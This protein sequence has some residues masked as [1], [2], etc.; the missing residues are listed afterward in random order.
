MALAT[1]LLLLVALATRI[2][3]ERVSLEPGM[4]AEDLIKAPRSISYIDTEATEERRQM[5]R[6][7][8][9]DQYEGVP[10]ANA[11]VEQTI[12]D[13]FRAFEDVR[14]NETFGEDDGARAKAVGEML[15]VALTEET[16][17]LGVTAAQGALDR[18]RD[19]ALRLADEE[20]QDTVRSNTTD[21]EDARTSVQQA[22]ADLSLTPKFQAMVAEIA[23]KSLRPNLRYDEQATVAQRKMAA[24][25]VEEVRRQIQADDAIVAPGQIV[26]QRHI[27]I[28]GA[29]GLM[30]PRAD[31]SQGA[32]LFVLLLA[33]VLLL[34][35]YVARYCPEIYVNDRQ[36]LLICTV[37]VLAAAGFRFTQGWSVYAAFVL[38]ISTALAMTIAMLLGTRLAI[39][40]SGHF[41]LLAGMVATGS[42][43][44]VVV[45]T[46]LC[47]SFA[48][49]ALSSAANKSL[50]IARAA[51]LVGLINAVLF[52]V[53]GEVFG[54]ALALHQVAATAVAG[55]LSA[56][57]AVVA[58]MAIERAVGVVTDLSLLELTNPN[59]PILS[60]LLT[61]APGTYQS[62]VMVANLAVPAAERIGA[63][64]L[65]ARAGALYH[66]IGKLKRPYFFIENQFGGDN[67]HEK[68]RPHLSALTLIAHAKDGYDLAREI[69]LPPQI[70]DII[71]EHHGTSLAAYPHHLAVQEEGA[72]NISEADYRYPGPRPHTR[73]AG[74]V[75]LADA[76]EAAART[77]VNPDRGMLVELVDKIVG[78][79]VEDGQLDQCPLTLADLTIIKE[80]LVATL[81]GMFHQRIRYPDQLEENG[82]PNGKEIGK[83]N[84]NGAA[85]GAPEDQPPPEPTTDDSADQ[86]PAA[87]AG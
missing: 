62:C 67:P 45:V 86:G 64:A 27:D 9:P 31:Y 12:N 77:L 79:K 87:D 19:D 50:T 80:S 13:V 5:S 78:A 4:E 70:A 32:A 21:L 23:V 22:V 75:M 49:F 72:E 2:V 20:M 3:P 73:E 81:V 37:L 53:T 1:S 15:D 6:D 17:Q 10:E 58:V 76:V 41:G 24:A 59:E 11:L 63:N 69:G 48:S 66:D 46:I 33:M 26:T 14:A 39:V 84:G 8:V 28:A 85:D 60:R 34:G 25:A 55:L 38:G 47:S 16:L 61:E 54:L 57:V 42:D 65:L 29:L 71:R 44:R 74:L 35:V 40:L 68:L 51:G 30:H 82:A 56:S 43:A 18:M 83:E 7:A 52:V 36:M